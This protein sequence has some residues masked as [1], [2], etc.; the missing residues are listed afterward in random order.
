MWEGKGRGRRVG[1]SAGWQTDRQIL[2]K[3]SF[4][5]G[6]I[7]RHRNRE[8]ERNRNREPERN[9][10]K[11]TELTMKIPSKLPGNPT[12]PTFDRMESEDKRN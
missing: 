9:R 1:R 7:E 3:V 12:S 2:G 11:E 5:L 6:E 10:N 4:G 8:T